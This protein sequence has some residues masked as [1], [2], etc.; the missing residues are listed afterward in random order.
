M[1]RKISDFCKK[2]IRITKRLEI[3]LTNKKTKDIIKVINSL[4]NRGT[5]LKRTI[6]KITS[7]K[8]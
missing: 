7:Q 6:K 1:S 2:K 4:K 3:T 8:G 5:L